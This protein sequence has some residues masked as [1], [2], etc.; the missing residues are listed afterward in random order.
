MQKFIHMPSK[1][2]S[3]NKSIDIFKIPHVMATITTLTCI[4]SSLSRLIQTEPYKALASLS[5]DIKI[6][7]LI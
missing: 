2:K 6:I 7:M 1:S 4:H 3:V 5:E